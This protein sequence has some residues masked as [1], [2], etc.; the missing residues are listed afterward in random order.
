MLCFL[1]LFSSVSLLIY[2]M[3]LLLLFV[4][5]IVFFFF[6]QKTAYE[7]RISDWS[8]DVCSSDLVPSA[9]SGFTAEFGMGSGGSQT[10]W[11]PSC[12]ASVQGYRCVFFRASCAAGDIC[13]LGYPRTSSLAEI[14]RSWLPPFARG[15]A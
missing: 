12:G 15:A 2:V 6:K 7:L 8:S 4:C 3:G 10:P 1:C 13:R 5:S 14:D 11:P 9:L